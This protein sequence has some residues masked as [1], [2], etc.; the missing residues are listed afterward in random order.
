MG[1]R[2][3]SSDK[4]ALLNMTQFGTGDLRVGG[5][6]PMQGSDLCRW[7][8]YDLFCLMAASAGLYFEYPHIT[9][10]KQQLEG[11]SS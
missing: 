1:D 2:F 4:I 5:F 11:P 7:Q 9:G 3:N 10:A 6:G 8:P